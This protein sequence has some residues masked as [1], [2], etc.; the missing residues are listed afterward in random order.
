MALHVDARPDDESAARNITIEY[1]L[2][3][4]HTT[5]DVSLPVNAVSRSNGAKC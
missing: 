3:I 4:K 5:G 2:Q 1:N